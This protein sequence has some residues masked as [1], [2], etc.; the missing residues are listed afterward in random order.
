MLSPVA[1]SRLAVAVLACLIVG[2]APARAHGQAVDSVFQRAQQ[3]V[4]AGNESAGRAMVDSVLAAR[5]EGTL[6]YAEALFWRARLSGVAAAAERDYRRLSVEYPLSPRAPEA[7]LLLAQLEMTRGDRVSAR[8]HLA[9]LQREHPTGAISTRASVT[10]ARLSFD[11]GDLATGC[12]AVTAA[13][14]GLAPGDVELRNQLDFYGP[15]CANFAA[16]SHGTP[17]SR[18]DS[19]GAAA[20]S[21]AA[22]PAAD[23]VERAPGAREYS[24]QVAAYDTRPAAEGL[25]KRL[26]ARGYAARVVGARAPYRVRV[27]RYPSRERAADV[28]R[29]LSRAN[30]RGFVVEAEPR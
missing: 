4:A 9:R 29:Q 8:A 16:R 19:A 28:V 6:E 26:S 14:Q 30:T 23:S 22:V 17:I 25:A 18:T 15:R 12:A 21:S 20:D 27:G 24:V 3:L 11:D 13:R 7:L 1:I 2:T 5:T 10:L